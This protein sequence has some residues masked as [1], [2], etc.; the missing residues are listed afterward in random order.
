MKDSIKKGKTWKGK[1]KYIT[2]NKEIFY[3]RC[4]NIPTKDLNTGEII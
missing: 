3:L 1:L 2:Q 4:T